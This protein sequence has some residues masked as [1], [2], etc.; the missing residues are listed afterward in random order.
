LQTNGTTLWICL[1]N[2]TA[3]VK[4]STARRFA[5]IACAN[6]R[7]NVHTFY[8]YVNGQWYSCLLARRKK[9]FVCIPPSSATTRGD[10]NICVRQWCS[11][12]RTV[13]SKILSV[14]HMAMP[15]RR[16]RSVCVAMT[17]G[18]HVP[19][20]LF[21][22]GGQSWSRRWASHH[23]RHSSHCQHPV[24]GSKFNIIFKNREHKVKL[25]LFQDVI[26]VVVDG[27]PNA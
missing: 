11:S 15:C 4:Y 2:S 1:V 3:P 14:F 25:A 17:E 9:I 20:P 5:A 12:G 22:C 16:H 7:G 13:E 23:C 10:T 18:K 6:A 21:P 27:N 24:D 19:I 26:A 8:M